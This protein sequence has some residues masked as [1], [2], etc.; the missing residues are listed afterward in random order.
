[1]A[2]KKNDKGK[3]KA[4]EAGEKK[5]SS[6]Q[7]KGGDGKLKAATSI[8]VRHI[9]VNAW[10]IA[11]MACPADFTLSSVRNTRR[12][13]K[14]SPSFEMGPS[15]TTLLER[16]PRIKRDKV[17]LS[18]C[19]TLYFELSLIGIRGELRLESPGKPGCS[20]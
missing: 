6:D 13:K 3:E 1:M 18:R 10:F 15:S 14:L 9:L 7:K 11:Y 16:C 5:E 19:P 4:K 8:N 17:Q 12:R 20:L 2:G